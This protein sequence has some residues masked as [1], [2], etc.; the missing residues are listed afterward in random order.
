[1]RDPIDQVTLVNEKD[2]VIGQMDKIE[3]HRG[4]AHRH[5][6]IS[7]FLWN[8]RDELL[9]QQ[10]SLEKI[11]GAGLW[12]NTCCGNV[13]PGESYEECAKRRLRE[14]L[15]IVDGYTLLPLDKFEYQVRCDSEFSEWEIDQIFY[16]TYNG[17]VVPVKK[18]VKD[19]SWQPAFSVTNQMSTSPENMVPWLP[20][21]LNQ[22]LLQKKWSEH[23]R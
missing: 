18:E 9:L 23:A 14:E 6:A 4:N 3:A 2:E 7:V 21:L 8:D 5:R 15:G 11:V 16:G 19:V 17:P 22:P 10:R 12:A 13:R 20:F 1:M